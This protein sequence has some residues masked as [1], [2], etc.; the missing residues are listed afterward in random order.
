MFK[1][2][3]N[4]VKVVW[5]LFEGYRKI[6]ILVIGMMIFGS[7]L[8]MIGVGLTLPLLDSVINNNPASGIAQYFMFFLDYFPED[9]WT[10]VIVTLMPL[11]YLLTILNSLVLNYF[12]A[13]TIQKISLG[14]RMDVLKKYLYSV[15]EYVLRFR[16][17]E[18]I[19]N[20]NVETNNTTQLLDHIVMWFINVLTTTAIFLLLLFT[21]F[22]VTVFLT[23]LLFIII[24]L[25]KILGEKYQL[26]VS[27]RLIK[28]GQTLN[29]ISSES[30]MAL[31]QIKIF[32]QESYILKKYE[33][34][35]IK[36]IYELVKKKILSLIPGQFSGFLLP[37]MIFCIYLYFE[38][39]SENTFK[40]FLPVLGMVFVGFMRISATVAAIT[41]TRMQ[42]YDKLP[43]LQLIQKIINT[44]IKKENIDE[45]EEFKSL[46]KNIEF[47]NLNFKYYNEQNLFENLN[48]TV[49][50][51]K[52]TALVGPSGSGKSTISYLLVGLYEPQKGEILINDK[53]LAEYSLDSWRKKIGYVTQD[54]YIFNMS[55]KENIK[56]GKPDAN[57]EE[58]KNAAD[59]AFCT[60]F[61]E[62]LPE[63]WD[64]VVGERGMKLSGGQR[65]RI[66]IARA[67]IRK[68]EI[69]IFDEAT[70]SLDN[71]SEKLIQKSI[72]EISK[73]STMLV[74]AHRLTT[75][76]NADVVYD[77]GEINTKE[78]I[79]EKK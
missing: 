7:V 29:S 56:I 36:R 44:D 64:T 70:S 17:G 74:I 55:I 43:S 39:F 49:S 42:I 11:I 21:D 63:K 60:E 32:S 23:F 34:I 12:Y 65:Q 2:L 71:Y 1:A 54:T 73:N 10:L 48:L 77:L 46:D 69:Y 28:Y 37:F 25:T 76:E 8:Q 75:I 62:K 6:F 58:V 53:N 16:Q 18:I 57:D 59:A 35:G 13:K 15:Y 19:H 30:I 51:G 61:I 68:P 47:R 24:Y 41:G 26:N 52:M 22:Y 38:L 20:V 72:E 78:F 5:D 31:Q 33:E 40:E 45:G 3:K 9:K 27:K 79:K 66:A 14:W 4:R 50:K 67:M